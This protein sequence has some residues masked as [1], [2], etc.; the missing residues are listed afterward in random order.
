LPKLYDSTHVLAVVRMLN[1]LERVGETMRAALNS[2]ALVAPEW[3]RGVALPEWYERYERRVENYQLP[4]TDS[5]RNALGAQ[6][7]TDGWSLLKAIDEA[8]ELACLGELPAVKTLRQVWNEQYTAPPHPIRWLK[9]EEM[10]ASSELIASPYD[11]EARLSTKRG[12]E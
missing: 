12:L 1:R 11:L 2:L 8:T 10:G 7:G 5:A 9:V 3:L 6:I 4:K